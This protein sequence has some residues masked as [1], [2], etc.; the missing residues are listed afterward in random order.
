VFV[1]GPAL[2]RTQYYYHHDTKVEPEA[3][4]A[5]IKLLMIGG[6]MPETC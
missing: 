5:V 4:T 6:K 1:V 2:P 3:A